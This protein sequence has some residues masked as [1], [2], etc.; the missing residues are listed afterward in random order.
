MTEGDRGGWSQ[1][2]DRYDDQH[3]DQ[4]FPPPPGAPW[5]AGPG[6]GQQPAA[7]P[8]PSYAQPAPQYGQQPPP[9]QYAQ[10][11][12]GQAP[13]YQQPAY[14]QTP[15]GAPPPGY[16]GGPAV[17]YASWGAR[18]GALLLDALFA[19]LLY[20]PGLALFIAAV[21]T[22][23][24]ED[25]VSGGLIAA[26]GLLWFA[27]FL[28]QFWNHGWRQGEQGWSWGKQVVGI[29]LVRATDAQPP[30]GWVGIGRLLLRGLL[31][32]VTSGLYPLVT[33]LWPLWDERK[34]TLDDKIFNTYVV[35]VK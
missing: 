29:K 17:D 34:Q 22:A 32:T 15:W 9:S 25:D 14:G 20:L 31:G 33:Y 18:A 3:R 16:G 6:S 28:V 26:G 7:E 23:E 24:N 1:P 21:A 35:R 12:Y 19:M 4:A 8:D 5:E 27:A 2:G 30:G 13:E 11:Q 10:Q